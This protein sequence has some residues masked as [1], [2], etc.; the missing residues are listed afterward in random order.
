M[1]KSTTR[2]LLSGACLCLAHTS[3]AQV[4]PAAD[5]AQAEQDNGLLELDTIVVTGRAGGAGIRKLDASYALT[6]LNSDAIEK[7][8]PKSTADLLKTVPGVSV[9]TSG[10]QNGA[11]IFVRGF[12]GGGDAQF[13]TFQIEGAPVFP[14]PTLSFLENSQLV[15]FD[16]TVERVEAVR[17]GPAQV[18]SN[19]Q[20]GLTVNVIEKKGGDEFAGKAKISFTDFGERR[21]DGFVSGPISENTTFAFGGFYRASDGLRD[22]QFT[23]EEGGQISGNIEHKFERGKVLFTARYLNDHGAWLLPIPVVT[24]GSNISE[25]DG[26]PLGTGTFNSN[27]T[28]LTILN[29]GT[30]VDQSQGRGANVTQL[31][32]NFDYDLTDSLSFTNKAGYLKGS[33]NTRGLVPNAPPTTAGAIAAGFGSTVGAPT[34]RSD[35]AAAAADTPVIEVGAWRVDKDIESFTNETTLSYKAGGHTVSA[36]VYFADFSSR[37][38]WNLGNF[39]LLEAQNNPRVLNL[40]LADGRPVT[41]DGLTRGSF[42]NVNAD[43]DGTDWAFYLADEWQ[44]TDQLRVDAGIRWQRHKIDATLE[45]NDFGVDTDNDPDTLYNNGDAVLNGTFSTID[46][47]ADAPSWTVG[48][49]YA[50]TDDLGV[51]ARYSRG[52]SFPQFD[53]LRDGIDIVARIDTVEAG[54][55]YSTRQIAIFATA[56]YND[57]D[58]LG[59]TQILDGAPIRNIGG[60]RTYGLE[61][62]GQVRPIQPLSIGANV[63]Y[64]NAEYRDFFVNNGTIDASGNRVQRQPR[65]QVR[66]YWT[67]DQD[68]GFAQA[69][70]FGSVTWLGDR[71]ED[72]QN[73]QPLPSYTKLDLGLSVDVGDHFTF[74]VTG[75]NLTDSHGLTEGNPR[76]LGGQG[77]GV[78][79]ARPILGRSVSFSAAYK[80]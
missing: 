19:G 31:G 37:D 36:G 32:L 4:A 43:Y 63:T 34:Y 6:T 44:V 58:G 10:G 40:T 53:D 23:A 26:F 69:S 52:N 51:F 75:D 74:Q 48:A 65:W 25:F 15:R 62:E 35:G 78:I 49:N 72:Q 39:L 17:G 76:L 33:A 46:Y 73:L 8:S 59:N 38:K 2:L 80:F 56:F 16:E 57:F 47:A 29:D 45:N 68:L 71:F 30:Q 18:F 60:A 41:R 64:L 14:P 9:E 13:V 28:R 50:L 5:Q 22:A 12:P 21:F 55:K 42:F 54:V 70:L 11:N 24:D 61:F 27:E 77:S 7:Y 20:V 79:L 67:Y 1:L 3:Y 66:G